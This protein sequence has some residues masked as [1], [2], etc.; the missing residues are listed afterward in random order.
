MNLKVALYH[1]SR[2]GVGALFV[3]SGL[4]KLN[5]PIGTA[6]KL[7]EYFDVFASDF[8][9]F[10]ELFV[11]YALVIA[12]LVIV[13]EVVLGVALLINYQMKLMSWVLLLLMVFFTFLTGYSAILNKVTDCGCFGDF[14]KLTPWQS[15]NKD[16][17]LMVF[18]LII[19]VV[20]FGVEKA[21]PRLWKDISIGLAIVVNIIIGMIAI[22]HLPYFDFRAYKAGTD[23]PRAMQPSEPL[24]YLYIMEKN[25]QVEEF[26]Q[27][28]MTGDYTFKE[29]K[30]VNPEAQPKI[31]DYNIWNDAGDYTE[32]SFTGT[33]LLV[34]VHDVAHTDKDAYAAVNQLLQDLEGELEGWAL[35]SASKAS[36]E[37]FR[38][39]VQL[40]TPYYF[41]DATVLKTVIRS[42]PGLVLLKNGVVLG[43]WHHNDVP[44]GADIRQLIR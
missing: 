11:P 8:A 3:F 18:V 38:H 24:K 21:A 19:F 1:F 17:I 40:A 5:D 25:G 15:F 20:Q 34:V 26:D 14:I 13:M 23:I 43:K 33:K 41:A 27:Y 30:L 28:P 12:L 39:E 32:A 42:N 35:T 36:F 16:L 10:F 7:E 29:M 22:E 31:T 44:S 9:G 37:E 4:V 6:I 2:L